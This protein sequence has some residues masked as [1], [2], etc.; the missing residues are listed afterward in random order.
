MAFREITPY[1]LEGNLFKMIAK[2]WALITAEADG[3]AN[4]MTISW[5]G[6]GQL[7]N[8][9]VAFTFVRP[10]RYTYGLTEASDVYS[11]SFYEE[12]YRKELGYFGS[13]SGRDEDKFQKTGFHLAHEDGVPYP[14]EA[15]VV[16]LCQKLYAHTLTEEEF[17]CKEVM[18][19][20]YPERDFHKMY[21]GKILKVLV[22][23]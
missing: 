1:E 23:E 11:V 6:F 3:K 18:E 14:E 21:V 12:K 20:S 16:L 4:A 10:Q 13:A 19:K 15:E 5:G 9:L 7:W 22:R 8:E 2:D 17:L